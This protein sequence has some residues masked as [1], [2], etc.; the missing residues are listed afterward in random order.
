MIYINKI[1]YQHYPIYMC[2]VFT[3]HWSII[4]YD[5]EGCFHQLVERSGEGKIVL[6]KKAHGYLEPVMLP[7]LVKGTFQRGLK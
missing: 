1:F 6:P 5:T 7:Y 4:S 3:K 2:A